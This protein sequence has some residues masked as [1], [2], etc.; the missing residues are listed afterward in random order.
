MLCRTVFFKGL[1]H[2]GPNFIVKK[3]GYCCKNKKL[4]NRS[5]EFKVV[6]LDFGT[7]QHGRFCKS[8]AVFQVKTRSSTYSS[9]QLDGRKPA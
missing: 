7:W 1:R 5:N 6:K 4:K 9:Q 3:L 8:N 2:Y